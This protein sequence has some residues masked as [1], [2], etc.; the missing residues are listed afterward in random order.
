MRRSTA[1]R[2]TLV[3]AQISIAL[4]LLTCSTLVLRSL[5]AILGIDPGFHIDHV[6]TMRVTPGAGY[7]DTTIVQLYRDIATR[8]A[9]RPGI[10]G[11]TAANLPPLING[12]ITTPIR[13]IGR[14]A[15][16]TE[17]LLSAM[18]AVTPRYFETLGIPLVRGRDVAW[19]DARPTLVVTKAA[20][21]KFWPGEDPIG[22]HIAFG[23]RDTVGLEVVGVAADNHARSLTNDPPPLIYMAF[24]G[25]ISVA[26]SMTLI[27]RSSGDEASVLSMAR[28]VV[29]EVDPRMPLYNAQSLR[30]ISDQAV[31]QPRL[32]TLLLSVFAA[33]ALLLAGLGIYGVVSFTVAQRTQEIGVRMALGA[34]EAD[35]FRLVIREGA[36]LGAIGIGVGLIAGHQATSV[37]QS[38][39][40]GIDRNDVITMVGTGLGLMTLTLVA[41]FLPARR[42]A[43]VD[44]LLAMRAE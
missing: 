21:A 41:T 36:V 35:V 25:A 10:E 4:V 29:H 27:V 32:N 23:K 7:N 30:A 14:A 28:A 31:A 34:R 33:M 39:L 3:V 13:I 11:V 20:A 44:P 8:L 1:V 6:I 2:R 43:Q 15:S 9:A 38:W 18:T 42:A 19:D 5:S 22:K 40:F 17:T 26:R 24:S 37:I 12:G 16:G